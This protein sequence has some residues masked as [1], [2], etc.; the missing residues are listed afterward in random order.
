MEKKEAGR[1][2][3]AAYGLGDGVRMPVCS[4]PNG[5]MC[6]KVVGL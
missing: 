4:Y 6:V 3:D 1:A 5:W 2:R